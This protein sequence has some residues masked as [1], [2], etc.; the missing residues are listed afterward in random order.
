VVPRR[1]LV[2]CTPHARADQAKVALLTAPSI[3]DPHW[4]A[5]LLAAE[6]PAEGGRVSLRGRAFVRRD[7][8]LRDESQAY[9]TQQQTG[10]YLGFK[11][12]KRDTVD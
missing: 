12:L 8:L 1:K 9:A 7:G 10:E 5:P 4:L 11:V 6:P 3:A 2:I